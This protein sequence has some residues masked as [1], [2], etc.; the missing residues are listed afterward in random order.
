MNNKFVDYS[1]TT[2]TAI[3]FSVVQVIR[4]IV[5]LVRN[6]FVAVL[7]GPEGMGII[8][9][10][11][12]ILNFIKTG[13]GLGISQSA[14]R[15]V[16]EA[17][18]TGDKHYF[19]RVI[20]LTN[21]IVRY[22]ALL[23]L[24]TTVLLSPLLSKWGFGN[25]G[26]TISFIFL[27][28]SVGFEIY[29]ENQLAI[30]KGMRQLRSLAKA[31]I[32]GAVVSLL[33]GVP[34]FFFLGNEGIVPSIILSAFSALLVSNYFVNKIPFDKVR[35][36]FKQVLTDGLPIVKMGC[37]LMMINFLSYFFDLLIIAYLRAEGGLSIIGL[38]EA[39]S[40]IVTTYFGIVLTAMATDYYPR[41]SAIYRDNK[42]LQL[43]V[44]AQ[45]RVGLVMILPVAV[46]FVAFAPV[47]IN[48]LYSKDFYSVIQYTDIAMFGVVMGSL[49]N[50]IAMILL[51]KQNSKAFLSIALIVRLINMGA[52]ILLFTIGGLWGLGLAYVFNTSLQFFIYSIVMKRQYDIYITKDI[53]WLAFICLLFISVSMGI[54]IL[55]SSY[56]LYFC[57]AILMIVALFFSLMQMKKMDL[58]VVSIIKTKYNQLK[59]NNT[60]Q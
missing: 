24:I 11:N 59:N 19:S 3:L 41:I 15:D 56:I 4:I 33:T 20:S 5:I 6:K 7:L 50:C 21:Q 8:G 53:W 36:R 2:K 43:E 27:G 9:V 22:T 17:N 49:S 14:V 16:S 25:Y 38:Y 42:R 51:A 12:T 26:Y 46:I 10:F 55:L 1:R 35:I 40:Q 58:D 47:F 30:L 57:E 48:V 29:T 32:I 60:L 37:A 39:G 52:Y 45:S 13:A 44:N 18:G 31:S 23:G 34:L 28:L 54:K